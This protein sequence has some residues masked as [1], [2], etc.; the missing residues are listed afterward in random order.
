MK[1][2][3]LSEEEKKKKENMEK[4]I[5]QYVWRKEKETKK[6]SKKLSWGKKSQHNNE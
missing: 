6:I 1:M 4:K 3:K 5:S 2:I